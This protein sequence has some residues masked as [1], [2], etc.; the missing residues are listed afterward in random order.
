MSIHYVY[1]ELCVAAAFLKIPCIYGI[2]AG[3]LQTRAQKFNNKISISEID[4]AEKAAV[5]LNSRVKNLVRQLERKQL[6]VVEASGA[7][8]MKE[9]MYRILTIMSEASM[10]GRITALK[11][12]D[13]RRIYVY[14]K[15]E[16]IV[17][18]E[19]DR[20]G[21]GKFYLF[22]DSNDN[23]NDDKE[24]IPSL[25]RRKL[26][27]MNQTAMTFISFKRNNTLY[28]LDKDLLWESAKDWCEVYNEIVN[29]V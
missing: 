22:D 24:D 23:D 16:Y 9:E 25:L 17:L 4:R 6:I 3:T 12:D 5:N 29:N 20:K 27:T 8:C 21:G 2:P 13:C 14:K 7:V 26:A 15:D 19:S 10:V 18:Q 28:E 1:D 11:K